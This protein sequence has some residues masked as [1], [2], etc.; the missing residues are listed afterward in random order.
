MKKLT[1]CLLCLLV[2]SC[3]RVYS[4]KTFHAQDERHHWQAK[5]E[6]GDPEAQYQL[7]NAY[8]CGNSDGFFDTEK[9]IEWWCKAAKQGHLK[10]EQALSRHAKSKN[11]P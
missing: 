3:S 4:T 9:A 7:G 10:A 1:I 5:A 2:V 8:C 6:A 11:C